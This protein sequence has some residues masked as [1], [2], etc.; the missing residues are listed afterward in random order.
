[1][2]PKRYFFRQLKRN[3]FSETPGIWEFSLVDEILDETEMRVTVC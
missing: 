3:L 2:I 1:M